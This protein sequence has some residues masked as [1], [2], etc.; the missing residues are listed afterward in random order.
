MTTIRRRTFWHRTLAILLVLVAL[1]L[2]TAY[3]L[4]PRLWLHYEHQPQLAARPMVTR[5]TQDIP[6]DPINVGLVGTKEEVI[7]AF[8]AAGWHPADAI[9]LRSS[10]EIGAS[11]VLDRPYVAAPVSTLLF[12]GRKQDLAFEMPVGNSAD[13]RHHVRFWRVLEKG[14]E[15]RPV[16]LGS[17]SFDVGV[18]LSRDT[19]EITHHIA[20]DVDADR[21]LVIHD[22]SKAGM[23]VSTYQVSGVGPTLDGRNGGG[24]RYYTDGE[25]TVGV[26]SPNANRAGGAPEMLANPAATVF[27]QKAWSF[28]LR[29]RDVF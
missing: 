14:A 13:R 20:P 22:L 16:W 6:G 19:G 26:I 27:K 4:L 29:L 11:V 5:T 8:A 7:R 1:Y 28:G 10:I 9:T 25:V 2:A 18:G 15:G 24:D 21:D 12:E 3:L 23:L 17:A